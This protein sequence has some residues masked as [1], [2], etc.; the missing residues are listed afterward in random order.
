MP[1][2][3]ENTPDGSVTL[4]AIKLESVVE[5]SVGRLVT[6]VER[7]MVGK[8]PR[9]RHPSYGLGPMGSAL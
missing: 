6:I 5:I 3:S 9:S 2:R 1:E 8:R 4:V 7:T